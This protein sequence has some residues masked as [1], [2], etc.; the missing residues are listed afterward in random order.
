MRAPDERPGW[1]VRVPNSPWLAMLRRAESLVD[2]HH[3]NLV[4]YQIGTED[5]VIDVLASQEPQIEALGPAPADSAP[6]GKSRTLYWSE[7]RAEIERLVDE[8]GRAREQGQLNVGD[9]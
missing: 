4:H 7:D 5:D 2:V 6:A 8:V 1:T 3:P 9:A